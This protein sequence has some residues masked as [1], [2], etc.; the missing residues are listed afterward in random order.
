M[1]WRICLVDAG[2][3]DS[4]FTLV[5][6]LIVYF[7]RRSHKNAPTI[8]PVE[9]KALRIVKERYAKGEITK[10]EF[11]RLINDLKD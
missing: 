8:A 4:V 2:L 6:G 11:D 9:N 3:D 7:V 10:E 5:I 1:V